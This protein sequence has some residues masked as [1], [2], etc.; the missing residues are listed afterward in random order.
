MTSIYRNAVRITAIAFIVS[1]LW[2]FGH[3]QGTTASILGTIYDQS[4]AVLPGVMVTATER[5]TGQKRQALTDD[6]GRF[7][8]AQMRIGR[9]VVEAELA[10]F[11]NSSREITLT[12]EGDAV[13]NFTM[14]VGAAQTE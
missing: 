9:Y 1:S 10:G 6:Q 7:A 8:M 3:G 12:L 11:Q 4:Q 13:V 2:Y 14:A 5:D